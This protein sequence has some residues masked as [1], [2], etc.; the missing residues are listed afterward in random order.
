MELTVGK[1]WRMTSFCSLRRG[2]CCEKGSGQ[3]QQE[4][5]VSLACH[6]PSA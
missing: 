1:R 5:S 3:G 4:T 6:N 2:A